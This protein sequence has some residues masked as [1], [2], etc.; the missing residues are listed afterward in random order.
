M[1]CLDVGRGRSAARLADESVDDIE[2][3]WFQRR[4]GRRRPERAGRSEAEPG[5]GGR[6]GSDGGVAV[7]QTG[8]V[9]GSNG[10]V[11]VRR[12][13]DVGRRGGGRPPLGAPP[14]AVG[15][16]SPRLPPPPPPPPRRPPLGGGGGG[17]RPL[18]HRLGAVAPRPPRA[19]LP[20]RSRAD[21]LLAR[22]KNRP[23]DIG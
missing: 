21:G 12:R 2:R 6:H 7:R 9:D 8:S 5:R 14:G 23:I 11:A 1:R 3:R 19:A 18:P 15:F 4:R 10:G 20:R 13:Q 17:G 22:L 16:R